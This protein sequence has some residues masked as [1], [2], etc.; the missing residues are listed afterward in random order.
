M[1][2]VK[3][4]VHVCIELL[5]GVTHMSMEGIFELFK[6]DNLNLRYITEGKQ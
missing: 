1:G 2:V 6:S 3:L 4:G 5:F